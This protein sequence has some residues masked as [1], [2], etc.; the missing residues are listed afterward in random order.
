MLAVLS[1]LFI[2]L[3]FLPQ[4]AMAK[5]WKAYVVEDDSTLTFYYDAKWG[6]RPGTTYD[7]DDKRTDDRE[8][9]AWAGSSTT[10]PNAR[11]TKVVFDSSFKAYKP[12]STRNWFLDCTK[13]VSF[14]GMENLCTDQVTDMFRMFCGCESLKTIDVSY[15]NTAKVRYMEYMF[16]ACYKLTTI[17]CDE[18]W[19]DGN[20]R[21]A[22]M[23]RECNSLKGIAQYQDYEW[24][25]DM[26]NAAKGYFTSKAYVVVNDGTLTFYYGTD[27]ATCTGSKYGIYETW[28][29]KGLED[30]PI[31]TIQYDIKKVVFDKSFQVFKP[32]TTKK[33]FSGFGNLSSINS[34][35]YL[36]TDHV[37]TMKGM[38]QNC[39]S[40]TY[41]KMVNFNT[42][43]VTD[44][45]AMFFGCSSLTSLNVSN[46]DVSKVTNMSEM[47]YGC[48]ALKNI[49]CN[50]DWKS[51][52]LQ[53]HDRMF[54]G[55]ENL[56]GEESYNSLKTDASMANPTSGYFKNTLYVLYCEN[57]LTFY[58]D[59]YKGGWSRLG[60][61]YFFDENL[62]DDKSPA[63]LE[64]QKNVT[65][66]VFDPSFKTVRPTTM[67]RWFYGFEKLTTIEGMENLCTDS[68]ENMYYTFKGCSSLTSI[69]LSH[70]N[71]K[72]V[73]VMQSMFDGCSDLTTLDVS[74]FDMSK[75]INTETM[76]RNCTDLTTIYSSDDWNSSTL[77]NSYYMFYNCPNL[78]GADAYNANNTG[79]SMANPTTGYFT[80]K[81]YVEYKD[82]TLTF[83]C[84]NLKATRSGTVYVLDEN[85][86]DAKAPAWLKEQKNVTKVVFDSSFKYSRPTTM[87]RWFYGFENLTTIEGMENLCTDSVVNMA[88]TF[89]GCS[90][91][92]SIDLSHFST[93]NVIV[94]ADMFEGCRALTT[95]DVSNFDMSKM[96]NMESMFHE[97]TA[98][99]TIYCNEDW[100][101]CSST[102]EDGTGMFL[103][104]TK[105]KG[106]VEYN[107]FY[108]GSS[109]ANPTTGYF[110]K[111]A[112]VVENNGTLT[113]YCDT[114]RASRPGTSYSIHDR[115]VDLNYPAWAGDVSDVNERITKVVFDSS[116]KNYKPTSTER[117]FSYCTKIK[118][119]EGIENL[120]TDEVTDMSRMFSGCS[121]LTSI[122]V[123]NFNT[124]NVTTMKGMFNNC[125][126][127][128]SLDLSSFNTANVTDMC[129]MFLGCA[130]LTTLDVSTVN[131]AKVTDMEYMFSG[132]SA[133]TTIYC[134]NDWNSGTVKYSNDMF[135]GCT[136]LTGA[137]AYGASK[138]D[139][140]MANPTKGYFTSKVYAV[141]DGSTL[142]FYY[143]ENRKS[144]TGTKIYTI[145]ADYDECP[146]W[147]DNREIQKVV[148]DSSFKD[149]KPTTTK[150]WFY[151]LEELET[152]EGI[153]NL[154]TEQVTSMEYMFYYTQMLETIDLTHF[155]TANVTNMYGM[156]QDSPKLRTLDL[157]SFNTEKVTD[158]ASMFSGC[159]A[160]TTIYCNDDWNSGVVKNSSGMFNACTNLKG[161]V[162]YDAKKLDVSMANP[163]TGYFTIVL[164]GKIG[165]GGYATFAVGDV[166]GTMSDNVEIFTATRNDGKVVLTSRTD[167]NLPVGGCV[168]L[169]GTPGETFIFTGNASAVPEAMP[170]GQVLTGGSNPYTVNASDDIFALAT[171][172]GT[173]A[174][175][176]VKT[177]VVIPAHKAYLV[178]TEAGAKSLTMVE[179]GDETT[180]I[181]SVTDSQ[182]QSS[183]IYN[184]AGQ[185]VEKMQRGIYIVNGKKVLKK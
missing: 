104:C 179:M 85:L 69:D 61:A 156:F 76:F 82:N 45:S 75:M 29:I 141:K 59:E 80:A 121:A 95:I 180:A 84:D 111:T 157:S 101:I 90:S 129:A 54:S 106:A 152:I 46:F 37:T 117:W 168:M 154:N 92:T 31:W 127:L 135:I 27:R 62:P 139:V 120:I 25:E 56:R 3:V 39:S 65:K 133:L 8:I 71:T 68:V 142:T 130:A 20:N 34:L 102:W 28:S 110:T 115:N 73:K 21:G 164:R 138:V 128:A 151:A 52:V 94:M 81:T 18:D 109:M 96:I 165:K 33:W 32:T 158:M 19:D 103:F 26:A 160:L 112:Y 4:T 181:D 184:L 150:G 66:V 2:T 38:F 147:A 145:T 83:Y 30:C 16:A 108:T 41:I 14:E 140:S 17:Y 183:A 93:E 155:N 22:Y 136:S 162:T 131:T 98:L 10:T 119:I 55:C 57:T 24:H 126:A 173:S 153:E 6:T 48:T 67:S 148:F 178:L 78:I 134:D 51:S 174:F 171:I 53:Y 132:C 15:F 172:D 63:W 118:T 122:N 143:D 105:L 13:V 49:F 125:K 176:R 7:I 44:M 170:E 1:V 149:Y 60:K 159:F 89:S 107:E 166:Q 72:N 146:A 77:D 9:P 86:P 97:C 5:A 185:R 36:C 161:A 169:K 74:N 70:F 100:D 35:D 113:F 175:Y 43:N 123:S 124:E 167:Y 23:F 58:N 64:Q 114:K 182:E 144:H 91:L 163:T 47:F 11:I 79:A 40:L 116:F 42:S 87:S 88:Y 177:G 137:V 99:T 50:D 12:T